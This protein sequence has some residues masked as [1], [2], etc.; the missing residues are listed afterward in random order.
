MCACDPVK[1]SS[2]APQLPSGTTR[3]SAWI[4][5]AVR[6]EVFASP[7]A[8]TSAAS[9]SSRNAAI[10]AAGSAAAARMST[11]PMVSRIRRSEP[12]YAHRVQPGTPDSLA[13]S[14]MARSIAV[15]IRIRPADL[16][17]SSMPRSRF[18]SDLGP[19][20]G[21]PSSRPAAIAASSSSMES[22]PRS[23]YRTM[24]RFGPSPATPVSRRTPSGTR[25]RIASSW[26][27]W[28]V[29]R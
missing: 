9:G 8:I 1:Y 14:S 20:P 17:I 5:S 26:R 21:R 3:R 15:S 7:L 28:P 16:R 10:S 2:A 19:K 23:V 29:P 22:M 12:A 24:A 25:A 27:M 6:I 4:P 18:S 13:M 11:S